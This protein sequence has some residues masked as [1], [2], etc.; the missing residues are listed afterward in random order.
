MNEKQPYEKHLTEQLEKLPL[1]GDAQSHWP[2]M[3][4]MLDQELPEGGVGFRKWL[5]LSLI[6][7]LAV[8][9]VWWLV[10]SPEN[11]NVS[12]LVSRSSETKNQTNQ[13][14]QS[15]NTPDP[16]QNDIGANTVP[17]NSS[18]AVSPVKNSVIDNKAIVSANKPATVSDQTKEDIPV[19]NVK[20]NDPAIENAAINAGKESTRENAVVKHTSGENRTKIL[21]GNSVKEKNG[22][23]KPG[24]TKNKAKDEYVAVNKGNNTSSNSATIT[25]V[26]SIEDNEGRLR[27]F[28]VRTVPDQQS[29]SSFNTGLLLTSMIDQQYSASVAD[30]KNPVPKRSRFKADTERTRKLSNREVGSGDSKKLVF[31]LALPLSFPISDQKAVA[32][33]FNGG[34]NTVSDYLPTPNMQ[35]HFGKES[36]LQ[37]EIQVF[38]PQFIRPALLY[39]STKEQVVSGTNR[40]VTT[41][42]FAKKLYYF[43]IPISVYYSPFKNFYLGSGLQFS[44]LMNGIAY[45][46]YRAGNSMF[47][48]STDSLM[49]YSYSKFRN[50]TLSSRMNS[51]EFRLL[52]DAQY[53]WKRFAVGMRYNQGLGNYIDLQVSPNMPN[54]ADKN[55]TLQFYLRYNL[56]EKR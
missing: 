32:Y 40:F 25:E 1:P 49:R 2:A 47:P 55:R 46:E 35:Y 53:Y 20:S 28:N 15:N 4:A 10:D 17:A 27:S 12:A 23:K 30:R 6:L 56:W 41:S 19:T 22:Y 7:I 42:I 16:Q 11:E 26:E 24:Q 33:N 48:Q 34:Q 52:L 45:S 13:N 39:Q 3:K 36:F 8:V 51:N 43:N 54:V 50:D 9:A 31:G 44:A 14:I 29:L 37:A 38:N 5:G 21:G 18:E